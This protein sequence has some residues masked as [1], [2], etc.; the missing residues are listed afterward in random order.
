MVII[1]AL[2]PTGASYSAFP[3]SVGSSASDHSKSTPCCVI[4]RPKRLPISG[5][6]I[7]EVSDTVAMVGIWDHH[8]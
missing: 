2:L 8:V 1:Q 7:V 4:F 5:S 3:N 6:G